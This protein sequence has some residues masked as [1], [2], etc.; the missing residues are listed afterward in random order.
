[1]GVSTLVLCDVAGAW[2]P[3]KI[4]LNTPGT[5]HYTCS[6][7]QDNICTCL[8]MFGPHHH[9]CDNFNIYSRMEAFLVCLNISVDCYLLYHGIIFDPGVIHILP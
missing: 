1:M 5:Q 7:A 8:T 2:P 4:L 6:K 3:V 9:V